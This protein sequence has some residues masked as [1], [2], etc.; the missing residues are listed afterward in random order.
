[1][2]VCCFSPALRQPWWQALPAAEPTATT[3]VDLAKPLSRA[4][5][6]ARPAEGGCGGKRQQPQRKGCLFTLGH[7]HARTE[8]TGHGPSRSVWRV[9]A[10]GWSVQGVGAVVSAGRGAGARLWRWLAGEVAPGFGK[11]G[12]GEPQLSVARLDCSVWVS[13]GCSGASSHVCSPSCST[14]VEQW[15]EISGSCCS[16]QEAGRVPRGPALPARPQL[17]E[18]KRL[19][20]CGRPAC[21][22][23]LLLC[24]PRAHMGQSGWLEV[25]LWHRDNC[26]P[27]MAT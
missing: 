13:S 10:R 1:M 8:A 3:G 7:R 22:V 15:W 6:K 9:T 26:H 14:L 19:Q 2:F 21:S 18:P 12:W 4:A 5:G 17:S 25:P 27:S 11:K 20:P 23:I 24:L 16:G